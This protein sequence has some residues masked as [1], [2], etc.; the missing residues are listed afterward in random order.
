MKNDINDIVVNDSRESKFYISESSRFHIHMVHLFPVTLCYCTTHRDIFE[1]YNKNI[2]IKEIFN[3]YSKKCIDKF[4]MLLN[5]PEVK[6]HVSH[7]MNSHRLFV[8][9]RRRYFSFLSRPR[10][11]AI[12]NTI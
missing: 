8:G 5:H 7:S 2:K 9:S 4:D 6:K 11:R 3:T 1:K 10:K 12:C